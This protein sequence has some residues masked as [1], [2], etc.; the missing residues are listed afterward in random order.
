MQ[1]ITIAIANHKGGVAKTTTARWLMWHWAQMGHT[2]LGIDLDPQGCL[3][4]DMEIIP[5]PYATIGEVLMGRKTLLDAAQPWGADE[6]VSLAPTDIR[7]NEVARSMQA[8]SPN[9]NILYRAIKKQRDILA[10][11]IVIDC[12]PAADILTINAL[13]AADY[14]VIPCEP[15]QHSVDGMQRMV[16]MVAEITELTDRAPV[17]IGCLLTRYNGN[18]TAHREMYKEIETPK[19]PR[20]L[21][22]IQTRNGVDAEARIRA[23]YL[24]AARVILDVIGGA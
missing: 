18:V 15:H 16:S 13:Y 6:N 12:A 1:N 21:D 8:S 20:L 10:P 9:H 7:L 11:I 2:C 23:S 3:G 19:N 22:V 5:D 4:T 17:V 24:P 14:V